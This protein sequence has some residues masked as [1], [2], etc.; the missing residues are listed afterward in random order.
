M[1]LYLSSGHWVFIWLS[2]P[3]HVG[4]YCGVETDFLD[5]WIVR[6]YHPTF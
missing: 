3:G 2:L 6:R 5:F 4:F 1:T